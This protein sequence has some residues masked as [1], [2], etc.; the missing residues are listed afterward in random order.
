MTESLD[1]VDWEDYDF[2]D[3]GC[4]KGGSLQHCL[5]RFGASRGLGIDIDPAKVQQTRDAGFD[6]VEVDARTLNLDGQVSFISMLD[7][8]EHLP[9]LEMVE[10]ILAASA[11][12]ARDF[13]YI[14]H[15]SFEGQEYVEQLGLR[16]YWWDWHGHT[17]HVRV[18][19][20]CDMFERLGLNT[21]KIRYIERIS[22]SSH[23]SV[24]P[25]SMP[26]DQLGDAAATVVDKPDLE[27]DPP[28]WR[29]QDIFVALRA[30]DAEEWTE[31]T[32]PTAADVRDM[33]QSGQ[34]ETG[35]APSRAVAEPTFAS[36]PPVLDQT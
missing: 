24:I 36:A 13:L 11:R 31:L 1:A 22:S 6:A 23:P 33:R 15:P 26:P 25:T 8:F 5:R 34:L 16:Q 21:Y 17:C 7:F 29:R 35:Q 27:L 12:S 9:D 4:S 32:K 3:L 30:F 28:I 14:K 20:Y 19:D 2:V 10:E 18:A